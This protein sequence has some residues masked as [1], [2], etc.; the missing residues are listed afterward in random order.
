[1]EVCSE[2]A[3]SLPEPVGERRTSSHRSVPGILLRQV[4]SVCFVRRMLGWAL[5]SRLPERR[6]CGV[7]VLASAGVESPTESLCVLRTPCF[8]PRGTG[9]E[10]TIAPL[11]S[12][13]KLGWKERWLSLPKLQSTDLFFRC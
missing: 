11:A 8:G 7:G 5:G 10:G 3:A 4:V 2:H 9:R 13:P 1:M 12:W 6:G